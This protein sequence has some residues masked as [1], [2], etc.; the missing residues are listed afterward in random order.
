MR[1]ENDVTSKFKCKFNKHLGSPNLATIAKFDEVVKIGG[2][3]QL[4]R[5]GSRGWWPRG[6]APRQRGSRLGSRR[7]P[8]WDHYCSSFTQM[9]CHPLSIH[10]S[11]CLP[12]IVSCIV[13]FT[14][15]TTSL[16][17]RG[18]YR[19]WRDGGIHGA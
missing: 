1:H 4:L 16:L 10:R 18:T 7:A 12:T 9:I 2:C 19:R 17:F 11:V 13:S 8:C 15:S 3:T 6:D 5:T 14:L